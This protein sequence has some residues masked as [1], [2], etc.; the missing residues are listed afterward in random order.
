MERYALAS[1]DTSTSTTRAKEIITNLRTSYHP[2]LAKS[3]ITGRRFGESNPP[4]GEHTAL[5][6]LCHQA[7][8]TK[9][10]PAYAPL[11][12]PVDKL[13]HKD[14]FMATS[15]FTMPNCFTDLGQH[16][17]RLEG[18]EFGP[19]RAATPRAVQGQG[20]P[21]RSRKRPHLA[22]RTA[23]KGSRGYSRAN[24]ERRQ[25][26]NRGVRCTWAS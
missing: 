5:L 8:K 16:R 18:G 4:Y 20:G 1:A 19:R 6:R 7:G 3:P 11:P 15:V 13:S 2:H 21:C 26:S 23:V 22:T 24:C 9:P 25:P 14:L 17:T 12:R 10:N